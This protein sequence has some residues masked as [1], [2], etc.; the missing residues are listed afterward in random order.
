MGCASSQ[1]ADDKDKIIVTLAAPVGGAALTAEATALELLRRLKHNPQ[2]GVPSVPAA[3]AHGDRLKCGLRGVSLGFL[4]AIRTFLRESL[5]MMFQDVSIAAVAS[6]VQELTASTGLSLAE[7]LSKVARSNA[8]QAATLDTSML[9]GPASVY[10][11]HPWGGGCTFAALMTA[12][13]TQ[14]Q[15]MDEAQ[16]D[17]SEKRFIWIDLFAVSQGLLAGAYPGRQEQELGLILDEAFA[18]VRDV[19]VWASPLAGAWTATADGVP[20]FSEAA[21]QAAQDG[22][23]DDTSGPV[24]LSRAWCLLELA[25]AA[26]MRATVHLVLSAADESALRAT[27]SDGFDGLARRFSQVDVRGSKLSRVGERNALRLRIER[28]E[29]RVPKFNEAVRQLLCAWLAQE[30]NRALSALP[31]AAFAAS[32]LLPKVAAVLQRLQM[33]AEAELLF[34]EAL[35]SNRAAHKQAPK[36]TDVLAAAHALGG[37]L[38]EMA[39]ATAGSSSSADAEAAPEEARAAEAQALLEE[40]VS[41]RAETLGASHADTVAS[42]RALGRLLLQRG[43]LE[44]AADKLRDAAVTLQQTDGAADPQ[45][46]LSYGEYADALREQG[47]VAKLGGAKA[48]LRAQAAIAQRELGSGDATTLMLEAKYAQTLIAEGAADGLAKLAA[49]VGA[50]ASLLGDDHPETLRYA[51]ALS[52]T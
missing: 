21:P 12:V 16:L 41:G 25:M 33:F 13:E 10:L 1:P 9:V 31:A 17:A 27:V 29:G 39:S 46:L 52:Y 43:F 34:R 20:L 18:S 2:I 4:R 44:Q 19:L 50:M 28:Y 51:E 15:E 32:P 14:L 6:L 22:D 26:S 37:L 48:T 35:A 47:D 36:H 42:K 30:A 23:G 8:G 45:T 3:I 11:V 49:T 7:S 5:D 38:A 24:V 40:A